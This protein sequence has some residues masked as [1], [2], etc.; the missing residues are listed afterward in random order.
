MKLGEEKAG[1][2]THS[3]LARGTGVRRWGSVYLEGRAW[4]SELAQ[5][6]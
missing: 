1:F 5:V 3:Q 6:S 4:G 2:E